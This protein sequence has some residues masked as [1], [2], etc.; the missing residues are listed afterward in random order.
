VSENEKKTLSTSGELFSSERLIAR[1]QLLRSTSW[2]GC[3]SLILPN[4]HTKARKWYLSCKY[5]CYMGYRSSLC[6]NDYL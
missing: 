6:F 5:V 2:G 3:N 1:S 4:K